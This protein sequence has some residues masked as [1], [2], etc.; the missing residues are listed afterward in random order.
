[1][2]NKL[3]MEVPV[4]WGPRVGRET[5]L[6]LEEGPCMVMSPYGQDWG[7]GPLSSEVPMWA[8][9]SPCDL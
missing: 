8:G 6:G 4:W 2:V 7:Q 5:E 9:G 3:S 1:M